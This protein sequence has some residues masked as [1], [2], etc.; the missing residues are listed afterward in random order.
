[1]VGVVGVNRDVG[2]PGEQEAHEPLRVLREMGE[3][4]D[5][6]MDMLRQSQIE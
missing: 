5:E 2:G 6:E 4:F 3:A 1:M